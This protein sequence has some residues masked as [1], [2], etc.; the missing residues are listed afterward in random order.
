MSK[1]CLVRKVDED[2]ICTKSIVEA[3]IACHNRHVGAKKLDIEGLNY[4]NIGMFKVFKEDIKI[5]KLATK[6]KYGWAYK[7]YSGDIHATSTIN[8]LVPSGSSGY[9]TYDKAYLVTLLSLLHECFKF[10][11]KY[12]ELSSGFSEDDFNEYDFV[13]IT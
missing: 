6:Y 12:D 5:G 9:S 13:E 4:N 3:S 10:V 7:F 8:K 1:Y 11:I 2:D